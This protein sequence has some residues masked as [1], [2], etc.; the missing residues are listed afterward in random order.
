MRE[1]WLLGAAIC[2]FGAAI[3]S[4]VNEY[5]FKAI[6]IVIVKVSVSV[7]VLAFSL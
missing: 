4:Y 3:A 6:R 5:V 7:V 1:F 2:F